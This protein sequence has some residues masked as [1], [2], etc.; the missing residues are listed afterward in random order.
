MFLGSWVD[1]GMAAEV[2]TNHIAQ[3]YLWLCLPVR[4]QHGSLLEDKLCGEKDGLSLAALAK[5][6]DWL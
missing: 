4:A 1:V 6:L 5:R 3:P 2:Q